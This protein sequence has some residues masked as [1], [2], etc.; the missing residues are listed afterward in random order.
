MSEIMAPHYK[1]LRSEESKLD[2]SQR[3]KLRSYGNISITIILIFATFAA[4]LL[5]TRY[6]SHIEI[7]ESRNAN[8]TEIYGE[9]VLLLLNNIESIMRATS[10]EV[11]IGKKDTEL[12]E[13]LVSVAAQL[14][15]LRT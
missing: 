10:S 8:L 2:N 12:H 5:I 6:R 1:Q 4:S 7:A 13:F 15:Q 9:N 11:K 14:P 3:F